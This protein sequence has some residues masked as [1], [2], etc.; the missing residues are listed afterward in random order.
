MA[1]RPEVV[2]DFPEGCPVVLTP[3]LI[4]FARLQVRGIR[5]AH[6]TDNWMD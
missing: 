5:V 6:W 1:Q 3:N 4:E 2:R